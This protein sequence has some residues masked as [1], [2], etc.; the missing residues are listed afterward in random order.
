[1]VIL[2]LILTYLKADKKINYPAIECSML[3]RNI[4][5][6]PVMISK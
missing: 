4:T 1:M 5:V 2:I 3:K 6:L